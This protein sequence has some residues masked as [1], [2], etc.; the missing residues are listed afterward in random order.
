MH[1]LQTESIWMRGT[2]TAGEHAAVASALA[3]GCKRLTSEGMSSTRANGPTWSSRRYRFVVITVSHDRLLA[4]AEHLAPAAVIRGSAVI[5]RTR[6]TTDW[7]PP[8][9]VTGVDRAT[10]GPSEESSRL[11]ELGGNL[12][13][14]RPKRILRGRELS[15]P[16]LSLYLNR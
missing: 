6:A 7:R 1:P 12:A 5:L 16:V 11:G 15:L 10:G 3:A 14:A 13:L 2:T 9:L 4:A 8:L